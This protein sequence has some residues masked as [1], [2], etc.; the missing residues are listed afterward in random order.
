MVDYSKSTRDN[1][2]DK[3]GYNVFNYGHVGTFDIEKRTT[4]PGLSPNS[5][6][7]E[8]TT[9]PADIITNSYYWI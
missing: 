8:Q 5:N 4:Y 2:D 1:F 3:H 6:G 9:I 7:P